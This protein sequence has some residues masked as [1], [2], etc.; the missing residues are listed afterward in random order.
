MLHQVLQLTSGLLC[1]QYTDGLVPRSV[2]TGE[3]L[4][5]LL[6]LGGLARCDA[7]VAVPPVVPFLHLH[8]QDTHCCNLHQVILELQ[9]P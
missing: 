5:D 4:I 3:R 2:A 9:S 1:S 7:N 8:V 6:L